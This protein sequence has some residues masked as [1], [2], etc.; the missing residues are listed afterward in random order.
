MHQPNISSP[1]NISLPGQSNVNE[2]RQYPILDKRKTSMEHTEASFYDK[3][4]T[5]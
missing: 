2:F 5:G 4:G 3:Y 1:C